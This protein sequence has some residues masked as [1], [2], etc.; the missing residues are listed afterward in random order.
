MANKKEVHFFDND[1]LF[2]GQ[3]DYSRYHSAFT[4]DIRHRILGESTPIYLYWKPAPKRI[5]DYNPSMKFIIVLRNPI[6]RAF[7]HWNMERSRKF[8][9][10]SF[11]EAITQESH[12]CQ[13]ASP[14]Q[15]RIYSYID[16][17]FYSHQ[18]KRLWTLFPKNQTL[19]IKHEDLKFKPKEV[20]D[21]VCCFLSVEKIPKLE[22][23]TIFDIPYEREMTEK[24][25]K[26]LINIFREEIITLEKLLN[27]NCDSWLQPYG[28]NR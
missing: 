13:M 25:T 23:K 28:I 9:K 12:K 6:E 19:F 8:E 11:W 14:N 18:I 15:H 4:P 7:S 20:V 27:W 1:E 24:E 10:L 22:K 16:R 3:I 5:F 21:Q 17:G 26:Y 2:S